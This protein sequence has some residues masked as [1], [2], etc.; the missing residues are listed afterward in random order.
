M[1]VTNPIPEYEIVAPNQAIISWKND[2]ITQQVLDIVKA[3]IINSSV[4]IGKGETLGENMIQDTARAVGYTE[5]LEFLSDLL[6]LRFVT[7]TKE[8]I[9][10]KGAKA[11]R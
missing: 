2:L 3:E 6:E 7:E 9:D 5:G 4:R 8:D 1:Q 10:E 11:V